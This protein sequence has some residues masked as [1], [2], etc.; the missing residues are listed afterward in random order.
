MKNNKNSNACENITMDTIIVT[1]VLLETISDSHCQPSLLYICIC[2][3]KS[4]YTTLHDLYMTEVTVLI[5]S[6]NYI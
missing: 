2:C 6:L 4:T 1:V 5:E 3:H